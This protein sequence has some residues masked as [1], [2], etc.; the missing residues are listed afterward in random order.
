M[1]KIYFTAHSRS[2]L[3]VSYL[4]IQ[5]QNSIF[6]HSYLFPFHFTIMI[7]RFFFVYTCQS[8]NLFFHWRTRV[9]KMTEFH[10]VML[11]YFVEVLETNDFHAHFNI[12]TQHVKQF[13]LWIV[14]SNIVPAKNIANVMIAKASA[15]SKPSKIIMFASVH[16]QYLKAT[17]TEQLWQV[18]QAILAVVAYGRSSRAPVLLSPLPRRTKSRGSS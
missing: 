7:F 12:A 6:F 8:W 13:L 9:E 3:S 2:A 11:V 1:N 18:L 5:F 17:S 10:F 16:D 4:F 14:S 15:R